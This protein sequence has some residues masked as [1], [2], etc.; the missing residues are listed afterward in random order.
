MSLRSPESRILRTSLGWAVIA[1]G[2]AIAGLTEHRLLADDAYYY[3]EVARNIAHGEGVTF[4]SLAPT[5]GFHPLWTWVLVPVFALFGDTLWLPIRIAVC[6]SVVCVAATAIVIQGLLARLGAPRAGELA[7]LTWLLNPFT[8]VLALRGMPV[9]LA[10]LLFAVSIAWVARM[11][12]AEDY[13]PRAMAVLGLTVGAFGLARTDAVLWAASAGAVIAWG[14][15]RAGRVRGLASGGLAAVAATLLVLAPWFAWC[16]DTFGSILQTSQQAKQMFA[17]YGTLP[18]LVTAD[19]SGVERLLAAIGGAGRNLLYALLTP[20][21]FVTGEEFSPLRRS[22]WLFWAAAAWTLAAGIA[23]TRAR[24]SELVR[25]LAPPLLL[26]IG[27]H[28]IVYALALR[29][30]YSW[31]FLPPLLAACLLQGAGFAGVEGLSP[32]RYAGLAGALAAGLAALSAVAAAPLFGRYP[33]E[34]E[35]ALVAL[36]RSLEPG[37]VAGIWN[38]GEIGYF[39]SLRFPALRVVNLD[40]VVNNE[41]TKR[42]SEGEYESYVLEHT[43]VLIEMPEPYLTQVLGAERAERFRRDHLRP[44]RSGG[45]W[46]V[47]EVVR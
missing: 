45:G 8:F 18:P 14:L 30:Y 6:L 26:F 47:F 21:R 16:L 43:D 5:N 28:F 15:L 2:L 24:R 32:R 4:D 13:G 23:L 29:F 34:R 25:R 42:A 10:T 22:T 20:A 33:P 41:L 9:P 7:A 3:F 39:M 12:S 40:G 17:L 44:R 37:T 46:P 36:G 11:R 19:A 35:R 27:L 31:Y 38:A 1:C